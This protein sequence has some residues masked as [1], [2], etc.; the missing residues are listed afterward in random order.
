MYAQSHGYTGHRNTIE[1]KAYT[2]IRITTYEYQ[3]N[4]WT[5]K[6][7][8]I[9]KYLCAR[10]KLDLIRWSG[11]SMV[12]S[13]NNVYA[14]MGLQ[15]CDLWLGRLLVSYLDVINF[16]PIKNDVLIHSNILALW[17]R[18]R[19]VCEVLWYVVYFQLLIRRHVGYIPNCSVVP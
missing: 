1:K 5:S 15:S 2:R 11:L 12:T 8:I 14:S 9:N 18:P 16:F 6:I 19:D 13:L 7:I 3:A 4:S 17:S 10:W